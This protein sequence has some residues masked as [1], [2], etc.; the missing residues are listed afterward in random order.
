MGTFTCAYVD[1]KEKDS[2]RT[3]CLSQYRDQYDLIVPIYAIAIPHLILAIIISLFYSMYATIR[4]KELHFVEKAKLD[5]CYQ[6]R[7][8]SS[9]LFN[10]YLTEMMAQIF[11]G[12]IFSVLEKVYFSQHID[13]PLKYDCEYRSTSLSRPVQLLNSNVFVTN[14][15]IAASPETE[16]YSCTYQKDGVKS[17]FIRFFY[18]LN[19]TFL[20]TLTSEILFIYYCAR[21]EKHFK[22]DLFFSA[23]YLWCEDPVK[24]FITSL[25]NNVRISRDQLRSDFPRHVDEGQVPHNTKLD[26]IQY[27]RMV[28]HPEKVNHSIIN[29]NRH[30][31][32]RESLKESGSILDKPDDIFTAAKSDIILVIGSPGIGK[33]LFCEKLLFDWANKKVFKRGDNEEFYFDIAFLFRFRRFNTGEELTLHELLARAENS[34]TDNLENS[35]VTYIQQNPSKVLFLFDGLDEFSDKMHLVDDNYYNAYSE[36][37]AMK[38]TP[39]PVLY[40]KLLSG[41]LLEGAT[42][43]TTVGLNNF[44][45]YRRL[46]FNATFEILEWTTDELMKCE[47]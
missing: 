23:V 29:E 5:A 10:A 41:K 14:V 13:F 3:D 43:I 1:I 21:R 7:R 24:F 42:V 16:R 19:V 20:F 37:D 45:S 27:P 38:K 28:L 32:Y 36:N 30:K 15:S 12:F 4:M 18:T 44:F 9:R 33:S 17:L 11:V 35:I 47:K 31:P 34:V 8:K 6:Q 26:Q 39:F 2:I 25:K 22:E 46:P 40:R